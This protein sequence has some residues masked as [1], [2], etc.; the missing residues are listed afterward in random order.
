M[1]PFDTSS[2]ANEVQLDILR[3]MSG[4]QRLRMAIDLSEIARELAFARIA[5]GHPSLSKTQLIREFL[6]CVLPEGDYPP[7]LR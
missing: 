2:A 3:R 6:H 7:G 1:T 4:T 5:G